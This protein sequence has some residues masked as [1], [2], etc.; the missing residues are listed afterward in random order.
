MQEA[1]E[2]IREDKAAETLKRIKNQK[3]GLKESMCN[4]TKYRKFPLL[5]VLNFEIAKYLKTKVIFLCI[6]GSEIA[7]L[8]TF[9]T[10]FFPSRQQQLE[11]I[12]CGRKNFKEPLG[13]KCKSV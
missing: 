10:S 4:I 8:I 6:L 5:A 2:R 9:F 12:K 11:M 13:T 3:T 1:L 7:I